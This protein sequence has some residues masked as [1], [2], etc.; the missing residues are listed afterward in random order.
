MC[1]LLDEHCTSVSSKYCKIAKE[2]AD[3][4][5]LGTIREIQSKLNQDKSLC[6]VQDNH[7]NST[8]IRRYR[9]MEYSEGEI[10]EIIDEAVAV[11]NLHANCDEIDGVLL[12]R[13]KLYQMFGFDDEAAVD[14]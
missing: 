12:L 13:S 9:F 10:K 1:T 2:L 5:Q 14:E 3:Y 8:K 11:A 7:I 6:N 4:L